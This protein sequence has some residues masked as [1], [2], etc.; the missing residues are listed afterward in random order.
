MPFII[1]ARTSEFG[2]ARCRPGRDDAL[3]H[4][5]TLTRE[6]DPLIGRETDL[7]RVVTALARTRLVTITGPGGTGKTRLAGAIVDQLRQADEE[8]WF[9]DLTTVPGPELVAAA[10][11]SALTTGC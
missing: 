11:V 8:A 2:S 3:E 5:G 10:I 6:L 7:E 4:A 1:P 9:I